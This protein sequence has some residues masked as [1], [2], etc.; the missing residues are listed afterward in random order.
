MLFNSFLFLIFFL[1]VY[2]VYHSVSVKFKKIVLFFSSILFYSSWDYLNFNS[3]IPKFTVHFLIVICI[4]YLFILLIRS[5]NDNLKKIYFAIIIIANI[6]NLAFFKYFYFGAEIVSIFTSNPNFKKEVMEKIPIVLPIAISFYTFQIIAFVVDEYKNQISENANF[7]DFAVFILFF[8]QQLAGP[9]LR[10]NDFLPQLKN[11]VSKIKDEK[12]I[13][14]ISLIGFGLLK[15]IAL[16][17]SIAYLIDPVYSNPQVYSW[18]ANLCAF[19]GFYFQLWGDFSGYSDMARG[20]GNL[21]GFDLAKNFTGPSFAQSFKEMWS[22]W[23]ITLSSF[24]RDYIYFPLGGS[25]GSKFRTEFNGILTM[26]IGGLWHGANWNF[27]IWGLIIGL[28]LTIERQIL[29]RFYFWKES[30]TKFALIFRFII[31]NLFYCFIAFIFRVQNL[32]DVSIFWNKLFTL[33]SSNE[34]KIVYESFIYLSLFFYILQFLEF[35]PNWLKDKI[36]SPVKILVLASLIMLFVISSLSNRQVQ[37]YYFQ[38]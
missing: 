10:A 5:S 13:S 25:K 26:V 23:H 30:R 29:D 1:F 3:N 17:D 37:F 16:A 7:L 22:R 33:S 38:F 12:I 32:S 15:K 36:K 35:K 4:N 27:I 18:Q 14:G 24:L 11:P 31:I 21:L 19:F 9:I 8:P 2:I 20:C 6:C 28:S 34:A